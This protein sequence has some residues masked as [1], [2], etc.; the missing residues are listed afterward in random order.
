MPSTITHDAVLI[1]KLLT[2]HAAPAQQG[3]AIIEGL[4]QT[5]KTLPAQYFYDERGSIL[6]EQICKQP[7]Y[8]PTRTEASILRNFAHAIA[9][10][11][12]P[13]EL[14]ELGSGSSTKTRYLLSA[15]DALSP[16]FHYIPVDVSGEMLT[17]SAHQLCKEYPTLS[18]HGLV[19]TY[20]QALQQLPVAP[21]IPRLMIFLGSTLGNFTPQQSEQ[22]FSQVHASLRPGDY[23]L[24]GVDLQKDPSI[25]EAAYNDAQGVTA[26][27]NRNMLNH[28]NWRFEADFQVDQFSHRAIYNRDRGQ[29]EMY[30]DCHQAQTV[31]LNTLNHQIE[32]QTGEAIHTEISRKFKVETL[33]RD[34][35]EHHLQLNQVWRDPQDWFALLLLERV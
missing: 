17:Q 24:L 1:Q 8:Y 12:G 14:I 22:L 31:T 3:K 29:I 21:N 28:L 13:C 30:L 4:A 7:E 26:A 9:A 32:I 33:A 34:L 25:L 11:T 16:D 20:T 35:G 15:Y 18:I 10:Q 5:P 19:G 2:D 6:F 23:F 27:F